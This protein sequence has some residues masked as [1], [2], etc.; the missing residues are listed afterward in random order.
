MTGI[1]PEAGD[2][3]KLSD[4]SEIPSSFPVTAI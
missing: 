4:E 2:T 3:L 1:Y